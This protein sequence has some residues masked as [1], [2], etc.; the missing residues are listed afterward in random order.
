MVIM[1]KIHNAR[2]NYAAVLAMLQA[3][4]FIAV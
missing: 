1:N 3:L 2:L 4:S